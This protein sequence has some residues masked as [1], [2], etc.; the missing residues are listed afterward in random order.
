VIAPQF[1]FWALIGIGWSVLLVLGFVWVIA[2]VVLFLVVALIGGV[3]L[4]W[5]AW[6][7]GA[8]CGR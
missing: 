1:A 3:Q 4:M 6:N 5:R 7:R 2:W 8:S